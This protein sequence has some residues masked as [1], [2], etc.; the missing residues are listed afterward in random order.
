MTSRSAQLRPLHVPITS[1]KVQVATSKLKNGK[2]NN[3]PNDL[4]KAWDP[5][6]NIAYANIVNESFVTNTHIGSVSQG[7]FTQMTS[8]KL[9]HN[10]AMKGKVMNAVL[11]DRLQCKHKALQES[12]LPSTRYLWI[13]IPKSLMS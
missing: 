5:S 4:V 9:Y 10:H 7:I 12:Q 6:C 3:I 8:A 2:S 1:E 11:C 13:R